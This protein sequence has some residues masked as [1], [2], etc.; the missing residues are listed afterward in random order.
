MRLESFIC[1]IRLENSDKFALNLYQG[2]LFIKDYILMCVSKPNPLRVEWYSAA[3]IQHIV[4]SSKTF[5][6]TYHVHLF[7]G[8]SWKTR[9]SW[10][11][12]FER[13]ARRARACGTGWFHPYTTKSRF[14]IPLPSSDVVLPAVGYSS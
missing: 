12:R 4:L 14:S 3:S 5:T 6:I 2:K 7:L 13:R 1:E 8:R 10:I 11:S 9:S